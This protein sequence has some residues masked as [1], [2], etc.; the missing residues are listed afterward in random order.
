MQFQRGPFLLVFALDQQLAGLL[1]EAMAGAP[2]RPG[3]FA[4]TS[5]LR[6]HGPV[7]PTILATTL[8]MRPTTLSNHLRRLAESGH[9]RRRPDASDGRAVLVSLTAK[10]VRET[11]ACFPAFAAAIGSY[12]KHL[13]AEGVDE[14]ASLGLLEAMS[15]ALAAASAELS[16]G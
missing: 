8:G 13:A 7:R 12:Q 6:L 2:L 9:V 10:G 14:S 16:A 15:R 3:E 4:V 11:E 5:A 1:S